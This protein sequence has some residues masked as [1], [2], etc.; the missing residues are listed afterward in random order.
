M[1]V[2]NYNVE[3]QIQKFEVN[4]PADRY[5]EENL[6]QKDSPRHAWAQMMLLAQKEKMLNRMRLEPQPVLIK[7][8][9]ITALQCRSEKQFQ[10][11]ISEAVRHGASVYSI[12]EE[13]LFNKE[14][15]NGI[16]NNPPKLAK[17]KAVW[18]HRKSEKAER[19][20]SVISI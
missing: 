15:P 16:S 14:Y 12:K 5:F 7:I 17:A 13:T 1:P 9:S 11:L 4:T 2:F 18:Q 8:S 6:P 10:A 19:P 20:Q 3:N